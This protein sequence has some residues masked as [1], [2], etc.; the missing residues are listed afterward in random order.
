MNKLKLSL[1]TV[2]YNSEKT[3]LDTIKSVEIQDYDNIEYIVVDG[4]SKDKTVQ[5]VRENSSRLS[6]FISEPDKGLYDAMNKGIKLATGDVMAFINSD[7]MYIDKEAISTIMTRFRMDRNT[8]I[9]Y[10]DLWYVDAENTSIKLR[11]WVSGDYSPIKLQFGWM[12]PHPLFFAKKQLFDEL[13]G[14]DQ[15]FKISAD[16]D[17][18]LRF[19]QSVP[20]DNVVYIKK[21]LL[22]MR[23]G[24]ASSPFETNNYLKIFREFSRAASANKIRMPIFAFVVRSGIV[25]LQRI[26]KL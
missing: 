2:C 18:M 10:G 23:V 16:Y 12:P 4:A 9:A 3:I 14:F 1:I 8:Q 19:L 13:G 15:S 21:K 26:A 17:L 5:I 25:G 22:N 24:G 11:N 20:A 7:D 6:K